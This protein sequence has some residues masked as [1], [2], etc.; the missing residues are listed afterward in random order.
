M[1]EYQKLIELIGAAETALRYYNFLASKGLK[2]PKGRIVFKRLE[3]ALQAYQE[4]P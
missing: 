1:D 3:K 2:G 4:K